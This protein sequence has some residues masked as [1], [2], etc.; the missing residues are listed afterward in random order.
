M[1]SAT[2]VRS[3]PRRSAAATSFHGSLP[4]FDKRTPK[5]LEAPIAATLLKWRRRIYAWFE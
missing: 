4:H 2:T 1:S 5:L 3:T